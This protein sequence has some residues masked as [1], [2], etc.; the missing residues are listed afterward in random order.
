MA[1][2]CLDLRNGAGCQCVSRLKFDNDFNCVGEYFTVNR[3][4]L[5]K[6][7]TNTGCWRVTRDL[8]YVI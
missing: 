5:T 6:I 1:G 3:R 8:L 4:L 7:R 2:D